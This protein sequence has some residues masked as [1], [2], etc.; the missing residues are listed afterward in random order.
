M[1]GAE[2]E[3]RL[4]AATGLRRRLGLA[5]EDALVDLDAEVLV[6]DIAVAAVHP[7]AKSYR[8]P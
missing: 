7:G 2:P 3:E 8:A 6:Y 1:L 5:G 4:K